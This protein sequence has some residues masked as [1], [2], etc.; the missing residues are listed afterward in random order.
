M[1]N[2][3]TAYHATRPTLLN[4]SGCRVQVVNAG[5]AGDTTSGMLGRLPGLLATDTKVV[6]LQPGGNDERRGQ[7]ENVAGNISAI[8]RIAAQHGIKVVMLDRLDSIAPA[9]RFQTDSISALPDMPGSRTISH[10]RCAQPELARSEYTSSHGMPAVSAKRIVGD[11]KAP[12]PG[13]PS[14]RFHRSTT[15]KASSRSAF[16]AVRR[17]PSR[18]GR[19]ERHRQGP[20]RAA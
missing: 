14:A 13:V 1:A 7:G 12:R 16:S 4:S 8:Q 18:P 9:A 6:V 3:Q 17:P 19:L 2:M 15:C 10:R 20:R 11:H 5:V